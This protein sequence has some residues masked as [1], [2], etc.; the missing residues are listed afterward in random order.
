MDNNELLYEAHDSHTAW[1]GSSEMCC[2]QRLLA[3][4][5]EHLP[6]LPLRLLQAQGSQFQYVTTLIFDTRGKLAPFSSLSLVLS[7]AAF[8]K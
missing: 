4:W 6:P 3:G 2:C 8:I 5:E 7:N 1:M